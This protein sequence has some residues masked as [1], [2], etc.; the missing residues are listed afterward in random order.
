MTKF[1]VY[2][3]DQTGVV[4]V[5]IIEAYDWNG[6]VQSCLYSGH[7]SV[8]KI[9]AYSGQDPEYESQVRL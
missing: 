7:G 3:V 9:E 8:F 4:T 1:K 5:F 2:A 6:A